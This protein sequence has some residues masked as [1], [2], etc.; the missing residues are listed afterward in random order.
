MRAPV[1][2]FRDWDAVRIWAAEIAADLL[3]V[4]AAPAEAG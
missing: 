3:R 2:D 4:T 1:G